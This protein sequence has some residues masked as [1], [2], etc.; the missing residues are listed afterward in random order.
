VRKLRVVAATL[1]AVGITLAAC[2]SGSTATSPP[3]QSP[4]GTSSGPISIPL[5]PMTIASPAQQAVASGRVRA[6]GQGS[7]AIRVLESH[8]SLDAGAQALLL[9]LEAIGHISA[10][11]MDGSPIV[12]FGLTKFAA[13][14]GPPEVIHATQSLP[15]HYELS[16]LPPSSLLTHIPSASAGSQTLDFWQTGGGGEAFSFTATIWALRSVTAGGK[17]QFAIQAFVDVSGPFYKNAPQH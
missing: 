2:T 9:R 13:G 6:P 5:V 3:A 11:C 17:C 15:K 14:E 10:S 4:S 7:G 8:L 12:R 16:P 1:A